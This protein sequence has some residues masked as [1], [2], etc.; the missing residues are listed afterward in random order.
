VEMVCHAEKAKRKERLGGDTVTSPH[1][2]RR[3]LTAKEN[4]TTEKD[5]KRWGD[6]DF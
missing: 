2:N 5:Q 1:A 6:E 3:T 4:L